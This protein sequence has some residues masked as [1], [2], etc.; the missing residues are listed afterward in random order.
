MYMGESK[1]RENMEEEK[2]A[3]QGL[4]S[5][6]KKGSFGYFKRVTLTRINE[7]TCS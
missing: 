3:T 2:T 7:V 1:I 4:N 5:H 6:E